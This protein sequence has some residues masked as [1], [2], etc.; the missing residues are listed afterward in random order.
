[1][2]VFLTGAAGF[3][4]SHV[5]RLLLDAGDEVSVLVRPPPGRTGRLRDIASRLHVHH[6]D[7]SNPD[8][9]RNVLRARVPEVCVHLAWY[10]EPGRYLDSTEN[11]RCLADSLAL[12]EALGKVG[13]EHVVAAGTCAEYDT[14]RGEILREDGP[15]R[16]ET[17][18]AAA[19]LALRYAGEALAARLGIGFTWARLFYLY[20][21][22]EDERRLVPSLA[23]ALRRGEPFP[24]GGGEQ[25][26][27]YLHVADAAAGLV[28]LARQRAA[29]VFNVCSGE[30]VTVRRLMETVGRVVG[31]GDRVRFGALP[32]RGW[33]PPHICGD[34]SRLRALGWAPRY[35]LEAGLRQTF[36][37]TGA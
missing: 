5:A 3:V 2:R 19:K 36:S 35:T 30:P 34:G 24:A 14:R 18:Y 11:L 6:G 37:G 22:G 23:G 32:A 33:D 9:V 16:P 17:L 25:V 12:I 20:G 31:G 29:G 26:R 1:M 4:G 15:V 28:R 13:C 10:A 27:D 21:P 7:L 8:D